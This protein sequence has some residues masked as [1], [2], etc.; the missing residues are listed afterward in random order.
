MK[1]RERAA[2][3][4]REGFVFEQRAYGRCDRDVGVAL[5]L[6]PR[7]PGVWSARLRVCDLRRGREGEQAADEQCASDASPGQGLGTRDRLGLVHLVTPL[8][9]V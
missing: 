8:T 2:F 4:W 6:C 7:T 5:A 9:I 3:G 1:N